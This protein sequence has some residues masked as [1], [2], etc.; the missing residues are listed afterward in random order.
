MLVVTVLDCWMTDKMVQM[1]MNRKVE[2]R[3]QALD[4]L[5]KDSMMMMITLIGIRGVN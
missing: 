4:G 5:D 1:W 3:K 2:P